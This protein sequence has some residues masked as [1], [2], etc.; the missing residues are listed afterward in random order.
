MHSAFQS[1]GQR[2]SACRILCV[3]ADVADTVIEM[4]IGAMAY[5]RVGS[6]QD[7]ATEV[8]PVIDQAALNR[9]NQHQSYLDKHAKELYVMSGDECDQGTFFMPC[10]YEIDDLSMI[11]KEVFG[12]ILHVYRYQEKDL[13]QV[14]DAINATGYGLTLGVHS[15]VEGFV[16]DVIERT[17]VG[18]NYVNRNMIGAVVGVQPF[19]GMGCS[20]TGPK[21]GGPS[22]VKRFCKEKTIS[23]NTAAIG[24]N[25]SLLVG[26]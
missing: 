13:D 23:T 10:V 20:G 25:V 18:N 14:I 15:R 7:M 16:K 4:L 17:Q 24:G 12:P 2:C 21:A 26:K 5:W 11:D 22:Y 8:G 6:P 1:A 9:L 19:G 3:Q